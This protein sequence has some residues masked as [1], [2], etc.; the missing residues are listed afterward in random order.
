MSIT[1]A[2]DGP[3]LGFR[4]GRW[5]DHW[6][7]ENVSQWEATGKK[8]ARRNLAWSMFAEFLGFAML[9]VWGMVVPRLPDAGFTFNADERFWLIAMPG[10][11]GAL[12]RFTYTFTVPKWGGRNWTI[13][14]ALLLMIPGA[15]LAW[16][17]TNP[18]TP[19]WL[20][21]LIATTAG[22]GAGNFTSSMVN[23]SYFYPER[24]KGAALGLNA[25]GGN[26]GTAWVQFTIPIIIVTAAGLSLDRAGLMFIPLCI[27]AALGAF[28]FMDN[29]SASKSDSKALLLAAADK[30]TWII[31]WLYIGTF[32]S[33]IGYAN[34]F[35][36][37]MRSEFPEVTG[38]Y[39]FLGALVGALIRPVGGLMSDKFGGARMSMLAFLVMCVGCGGVILVLNMDKPAFPL[40]F[41]LFLLLFFAAG[42]GNGTTYRMI[43]AV[44]R[45]SATDPETG[46][47]DPMKL[48]RARRLAGGCIGIAGAIGSLGAFIIPRVFAMAGVI[49][50]F[51]IFICAYFIMLFMIW[52]FYERSGSPLSISR[53]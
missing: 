32:G 39:V 36:T 53:V 26:L 1:A 38:N 30:N 4:P 17:V 19:F 40:F 41:A 18:E 12:M 50:G 15:G 37:L 52:Y 11:F 49:G 28:L 21:L 7:P 51:M 35:A 6:N 22:L 10:L 20:M 43:P 14:S 34:S 9:A 44:F 33:F 27:L 29:L 46:K 45:A 23:I 13:T 2:Y 48:V 24:S 31:A 8:I 16:A 25:S 3:R 47:I 5:I 42:F